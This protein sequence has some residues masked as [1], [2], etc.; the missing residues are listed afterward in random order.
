MHNIG[1]TTDGFDIVVR[2]SGMAGLLVCSG[3][4]VLQLAC[5]YNRNITIKVIQ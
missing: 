1:D 2:L 4:V 3:G 5:V